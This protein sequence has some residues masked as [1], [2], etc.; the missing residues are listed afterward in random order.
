[1]PNCGTTM[2]CSVLALV[3]V[4]PL[5]SPIVLAPGGVDAARY[6][7]PRSATLAP[8]PPPPRA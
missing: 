5:P 8:E 6:D 1:M 2:A 7:A 4:S 3:S